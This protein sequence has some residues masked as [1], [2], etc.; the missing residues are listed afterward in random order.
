M[1]TTI[2]VDTT[3]RIDGAKRQLIFMLAGNATFTL[4][5]QKTGTRFTYNV[6]RVC[7]GSCKRDFTGRKDVSCLKC[8]CH[9]TGQPGKFFVSL[10]TGPDNESNYS[11][12]GMLV[13]GKTMESFMDNGNPPSY[14]LVTTRNSKV[15][16]EAPS[17][18]AFNW[19][20]E[21]L[22]Q[23]KD[24]QNV[25]IYHA[26]KCGMCGRKLTVPMSIQIG[27]GPECLGRM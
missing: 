2:D 9:Q 4:V 25:E 10:L 3:A 11:H 6:K 24:P 20:F 16:V 12:M 26:G 5:S 14:V 8:T 15:G 7:C 1:S 27:I 21:Q 18:V 23:G 22:Q 17:Y 13:S 19:V